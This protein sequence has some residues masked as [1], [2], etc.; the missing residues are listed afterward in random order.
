MSTKK[1]IGLTGAACAAFLL[2]AAAP[3]SAGPLGGGIPQDEAGAGSLIAQ[4]KHYGPPPGKKCVKWTRRW[5]SSLGMG[6]LR[7]IHW[8]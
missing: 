1:K 2:A 6:H 5:H 8:H 7:C 4:A 3:A